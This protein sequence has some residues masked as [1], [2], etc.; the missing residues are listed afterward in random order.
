MDVSNGTRQH[1]KRPSPQAGIDTEI[2]PE[3][4]RLADHHLSY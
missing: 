3:T 4:A 2:K 1:L